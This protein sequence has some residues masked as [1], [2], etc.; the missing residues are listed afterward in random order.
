MT[1]FRPL[2]WP[3]LMALTLISAQGF[4]RAGDIIGTVHA[5]PKAGTESAGGAGGAVYDSRKYKF[6]E[7]VDYNAMR[8]FVVYVE[9]KESD[10]GQ[11]PSC[12]YY[13]CKDNYKRD[14]VSP[15]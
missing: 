7:R 1:F 2:A 8:D 11:L 4:L 13:P 15:F 3:V 10:K 14:R 6:V 9:G 12:F 5:E